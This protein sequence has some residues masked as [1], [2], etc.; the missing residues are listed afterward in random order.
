MQ[1][2][3]TIK[4]TIVDLRTQEQREADER[5]KKWIEG[6]LHDLDYGVEHN[7]WAQSAITYRGEVVH[8][9]E[10]VVRLANDDDGFYVQTFKTREQLEAFITH[11]RQVADEA[12]GK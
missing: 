11:L 10:P 5:K 2:T 8:T 3:Y 1:I 6:E 9:H 7:A 12:W 4:P